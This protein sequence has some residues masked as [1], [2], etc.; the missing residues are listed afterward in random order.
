MKKIASWLGIASIVLATVIL[1]AGLW[2]ALIG[3]R[4]KVFQI[5]LPGYHELDL[6]EPGLYAGVVQNKLSAPLPASA[7]SKMSIKVMTKDFEEV[8]VV[9][10]TTGQTFERMGHQGMLLF[11][12]AI[13]QPG[14]YSLSGLY[15]DDAT[16]PVVPVYVFA[17]Q[18]QNLKPTL[19]VAG[20]FFLF[21]LVLGIFLL[22]NAKKW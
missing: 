9:V 1:I 13:N 19:F 7:L 10:N 4:G 6:Q 12:F 2:E 8:P 11:N 14:T 17:Q 16:A 5:E 15:L 18:V 20:F 21:F 3:V 22:R